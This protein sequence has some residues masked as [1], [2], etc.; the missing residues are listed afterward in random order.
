M[1]EIKNLHAGI[2]GKAILNGIDLTVKRGELHAIMG[3]NGSG[4]STL[5]RLLLRF[6]TWEQHGGAVAP[7]C[8]NIDNGLQGGQ[9]DFIGM[10]FTTR[11]ADRH[12]CSYCIYSVLHGKVS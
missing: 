3:R 4:K 5:V 1:L 8:R 9:N 10:Q 11:P 6:P 2:D 7:T 12:R